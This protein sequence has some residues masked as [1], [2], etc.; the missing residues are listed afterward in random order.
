MNEACRC[1]PELA[2]RTVTLLFSDFASASAPAAFDLFGGDRLPTGEVALERPP[3]GYTW[4][5]TAATATSGTGDD[6]AYGAT[7]SDDNSATSLWFS[8]W[9][10]TFTAAKLLVPVPRSGRIWVQNAQ[11]LDQNVVILELTLYADDCRPLG[12]GRDR[13]ERPPKAAPGAA[14]QTVSR[15]VAA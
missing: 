10:S 12:F 7:I 14:N 9:V 11:Y 6:S 3:P 1:C 4:W 2:C 15:K 8:G 5:V 13:C